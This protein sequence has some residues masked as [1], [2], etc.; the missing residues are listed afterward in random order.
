MYRPTI[1]IQRK[2]I[3]DS[4]G[5][6]RYYTQ[7]RI[8]LNESDIMTEKQLCKF[9]YDNFGEGHYMVLAWMKKRKGFWVF[10]KGEINNDGF[11]FEYKKN[12]DR[13]EVQ[14]LRDEYEEEEEPEYRQLLHELIKT[15]VDDNKARKYGYYPFITKSSKR[16]EFFY[17]EDE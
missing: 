17:W 7:A 1:L 12:V 8:N 3:F 16:G 2:K 10:W 13:K 15:E 5:W 6:N 4:K 14:A 9:I 11:M